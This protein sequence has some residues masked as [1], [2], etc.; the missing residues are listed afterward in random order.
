MRRAF[1]AADR[2]PASPADGWRKVKTYSATL[3][4]QKIPEQLTWMWYQTTFKTPKALPKGPLTLW[5]MEPD[6][7]A[8]SLWLDGEPLAQL[9]KIKARQPLDVDL[10]GR[11]KADTEYVL[12]VKLHH[13]RIS[14]LMLGGLLRPVMIFSGALPPPEP[15]K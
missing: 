10:T 6:G 7:N 2:P 9:E 11:L 3:N 13:Q 1:S 4:E 14:E 12:T 8:A 5:F 15:T